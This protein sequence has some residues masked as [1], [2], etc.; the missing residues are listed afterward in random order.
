MDTHVV[1]E[2]EQEREGVQ[3]AILF[4]YLFSFK[5]TYIFPEVPGTISAIK[6]INQ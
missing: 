2:K 5:H 4:M 1:G 6:N 3:R